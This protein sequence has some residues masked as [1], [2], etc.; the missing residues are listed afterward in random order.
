MHNLNLIKGKHQTNLDE[1]L[2]TKR[3][4]WNFLAVSSE[5]GGGGG[6]MLPALGKGGRGVGSGGE[7]RVWQEMVMPPVGKWTLNQQEA[8]PQPPWFPE[9]SS[10]GC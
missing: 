9:P 2:S 4:A 8:H 3:L 5:A 1:G 10:G 6:G 7:G